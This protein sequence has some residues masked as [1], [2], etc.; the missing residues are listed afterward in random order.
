MMSSLRQKSVSGIAWMLTEKFSVNG[1]KFV[2]GIIMARLLSPND[3]GLIGMITI[4]FKIAEAFVDSG[5]AMA[6][7]QKKQVNPTDADTVF[8]TNL[9]ISVI[10]Y[11]TI[12]L[13]APL[14]SDYYNQPQL[15]LLT[16]VMAIVIVI[17]A[18]NIIQRAQIIRNLSFKKLTTITFV[19]SFFS[20]IIGVTAALYGIG[21]WALVVQSL[22]SRIFISLGFWF[23]SDYRP[24][25]R[26]SLYSFKK[27]FSFGSWLL[28][29]SIFRTFFDNIYIFAIGK[30]YPVCQVGFYHKANQLTQISVNQLSISINNVAFPVYASLQDDK[31]K[32]KNAIQNFIKHSMIFI[33]PITALL[34]IF[35]N[36]I[37]ILLLTEKWAPMVPY[38]QLT[39]IA[40][41]LYPINHINIQSIIALGKSGVAFNLEV[42]KNVLRFVNVLVNI[43]HGII[44]ILVGEVVINMLFFFIN[45]LFCKKYTDYSI[46]RQI[47]DIWKIILGGIL[48]SMIAIFINIGINNNV[49]CLILGVFFFGLIYLFIEYIL[50]RELVYSSIRAIKILGR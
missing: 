12:Y 17:N 14:I 11:F 3:F 36:P 24:K 27:M 16:R 4:F 15:I 41:I 32:L 5:F 1:V 39:C 18:F 7:V 9:I 33:V 10:F 40:S 8:Y 45:A 43:K 20:G 47:K 48:A 35:A 25:L 38:F 22:C 37:I 28:F 2:L 50:N 13:I 6:Y 21:V 44:N 30:Y 26:F 23:V 19:S 29:S 46:Y 31:K 49:L 34:I 42:G